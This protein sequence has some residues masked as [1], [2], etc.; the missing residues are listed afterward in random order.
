MVARHMTETA[1]I[2]LGVVIK[3]NYFSIDP[4]TGMV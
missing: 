1:D 3:F 2:E 4:G